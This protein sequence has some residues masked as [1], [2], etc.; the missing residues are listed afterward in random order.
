MKTFRTF[1]KKAESPQQQQY[2]YNQQA[3]YNEEPEQDLNQE[4]D[5]TDYQVNNNYRQVTRINNDDSYDQDASNKN[6]EGGRYNVKN[7]NQV[8]MYSNMQENANAKEND[9]EDNENEYETDASQEPNKKAK[10]V[11]INDD[12]TTDEEKPTDKDTKV[13]PREKYGF[14]FATKVR[15]SG[16]WGKVYLRNGTWMVIAGFIQFCISIVLIGVFWGFWYSNA[17]NFPMRT[18]AITLLSTGTC[19]K[20]ELFYYIDLIFN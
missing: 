9:V 3:N 18:L 10:S 5:F 15:N 4:E 1:G 6:Y 16:Y 19:H 7:P 14:H 11:R 20:K 2:S 12:Y 13:E 17:L 8:I